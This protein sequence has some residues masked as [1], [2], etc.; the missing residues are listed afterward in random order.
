M[1]FAIFKGAGAGASQRLLLLCVSAA[2]TLPLGGCVASLA[3]GAVSM[4]V[5]AAQGQPRANQQLTPQANEAC[6]ARA[7]QYGT[8]RI[9]DV[10][11]HTASRI[12]VWGTSD[13]GKQRRSFKCAFGTKV[14]AFRVRAITPAR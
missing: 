9:I 14:D 5:Q 10:E 2:A 3:T 6:T 11:Q 8:V 7:A 12:I 13:D 1:G 4:A